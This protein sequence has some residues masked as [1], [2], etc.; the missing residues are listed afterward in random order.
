[1]R[2]F[3]VFCSL[4]YS[5]R[6][7][8]SSEVIKSNRG[9]WPFKFCCACELC[10]FWEKNLATRHI[11]EKFYH[12][13]FRPLTTEVILL[14]AKNKNKFWVKEK[15][16][17]KDCVTLNFVLLYEDRSSNDSVLNIFFNR[18]LKTF[19]THFCCKKYIFGA[20]KRRPFSVPQVMLLVFIF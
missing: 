18:E 4:S 19:L 20:I 7:V 2:L 13:A 9:I 12:V 17:N 14:L 5:R 16:L 3:S 8:H 10:T 15:C 1:M 11:L 6:S